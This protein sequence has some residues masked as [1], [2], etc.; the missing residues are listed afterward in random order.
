VDEEFDIVLGPSRG[1]SI[2]EFKLREGFCCR[3]VKLPQGKPDAPLRV[4]LH[5]PALKEM[6]EHAGSETS[7]EIG[8][9][10]VGT[11]SREGERLVAEVVQAIPATKGRSQGHSFTFSHEAWD[12]INDSLA[13]NEERL[14]LIGW[15][16]TH[17]GF[18]VF[19]SGHDRFAHLSFFREPFQFAL[20]IDP[21]RW[22]TGLFITVDGRVEMFNSLETACP[23]EEAAEMDTYIETWLQSRD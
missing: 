1:P 16:H 13:A 2:P 18:E 7:V 22:E 21:V 6:M 11:P 12:E 3:Q 17:P 4:I 20:V 19:F 9:M 8:G 15:Y 23:E 5:F 14:S 10:L